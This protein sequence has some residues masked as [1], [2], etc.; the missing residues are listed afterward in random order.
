[1][2]LAAPAG[3]ENRSPVARA[4]VIFAGGG[5][6]K[7]PLLRILS[8]VRQGRLRTRRRR[9]LA[10]PQSNPQLEVIQGV[11]ADIVFL[12]MNENPA[13]TAGQMSN[14]VV[15]TTVRYAV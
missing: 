1:M 2:R 13:L 14:P 4:A 8:L 9:G 15:H 12:P 6:T 3:H 10:H 7:D 5:T 11:G